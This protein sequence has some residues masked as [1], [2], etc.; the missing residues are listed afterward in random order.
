MYV[1][2]HGDRD[3]TFTN[4]FDKTKRGYDNIA[5][6]LWQQAIDFF[7]HNYGIYIDLDWGI[8][9]GYRF[10]PVGTDLTYNWSHF[11]DNHD[12]DYPQA[13]KAAILKAIEISKKQ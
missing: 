4:V 1:P 10:I 6:P 2:N 11:E 12:W 5:A 7:R 8:G 3:C 9:W 13:R